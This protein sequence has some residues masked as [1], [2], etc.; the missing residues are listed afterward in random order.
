[1][2]VLEIRLSM[3]TNN[4]VSVSRGVRLGL[5]WL[6]LSVKIV[7]KAL[8][9]TLA[10]VHVADGVNSLGELH[11]TGKL[12]V[13][14]APVV[15]NSFQM[16]L[17]DKHH[18]FISRC[19]V[20][21]GEKLFVFLI[22]KDLF[23]FGEKNFHWFNEP[24]Y[25]VLVHALFGESGRSNQADLCPVWIKLLSPEASVVL[26]SLKNEVRSVH[27]SL[28]VKTLPGRC[29]HLGSS[30]H[31]FSSNLLSS[32]AGKF[33]FKTRL[34][35]VEIEA[36]S[37]MPVEESFVN[38]KTSKEN[39]FTIIEVHIDVWLVD[40]GVELAAVLVHFLLWVNV[41]EEFG[42]LPPVITSLNNDCIGFDFF[43]KFFSALGQHG[44]VV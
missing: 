5:G 40:I 42:G 35:E 23:K 25:H 15:L 33:S 9:E 44:G 8:E 39:P 1:M 16:P 10:Q 7:V 11:R 43:N 2:L 27:T 3:V 4:P 31:Q 20:Y 36:K 19:F 22:N 6:N 14:V 41:V 34:P 32:F 21:F 30:K 28:V 17:I 26:P 13:S 38:G 18:D 29:V 37:E 12:T 24:I